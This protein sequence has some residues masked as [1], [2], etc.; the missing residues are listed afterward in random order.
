MKY[1]ECFQMKINSSARRSTK[2]IKIEEKVANAIHCGKMLRLTILRNEVN[3]VEIERIC[4]KDLR[5]MVTKES[6]PRQ[7]NL[8]L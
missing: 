2:T 1:E 5:V 6:N 8:C 4:E 3:G 7:L